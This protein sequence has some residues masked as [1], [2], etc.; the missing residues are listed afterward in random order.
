LPEIG[1]TSASFLIRNSSGSMPQA[2]AI[3]SIALSSAID[4]V[5]SPG[6]RMK[7]GVPL[8]TRATSCAVRIAGLA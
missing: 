5:A 1:S 7:S 2:K 4:P 8:S 6:A 3:S